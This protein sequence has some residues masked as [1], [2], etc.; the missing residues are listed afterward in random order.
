MDDAS[1]GAVPSAVGSAGRGWTQVPPNADASVFVDRLTRALHTIECRELGPEAATQRFGPFAD[2]QEGGVFLPIDAER[3]L[4]QHPGR[5]D[6]RELL[7][8][9]RDRG[10]AVGVTLTPPA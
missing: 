9:V 1:S 3:L 10:P 8:A 4:T 5:D 7:Q 2:T 6:L